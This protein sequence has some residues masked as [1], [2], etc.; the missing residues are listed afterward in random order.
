MR[1]LVPG[2][3]VGAVERCNTEVALARIDPATGVLHEPGHPLDG[4]SLAGKVLAC[5]GR[6]GS[7]SGS[8]ILMNLAHRGLAPAA[9]LVGRAD[10]VLVAGAVLGR[11]PLA[12]GINPCAFATGAKVDLDLP[13]SSR[14]AESPS[15]RILEAVGET[16]GATEMIPVASAH[17]GLSLSS[18]GETGVDFLESLVAR[19]ERFVVPATTNVLSF[20]RDELSSGEARLQRRALDALVRLGARANCSC[21]PFDQGL[22]PARGQSVAWSES[23][24]A[25]YVNGVLGARTNREGATALASALAGVTPRYGMHVAEHR[26]PGPRFRVTARLDSLDRFHLL[27]AAV[28]RRCGGAIPALEGLPAGSGLEALYG[29]SAALAAHS[30]VPMFHAVGVTPEAADLGT[31]YPEGAPRADV[32]DD[33]ALEAER[34]HWP[35]APGAPD[36]VVI[37]CPHATARQLKELAGLLRGLRVAKTRFIVHASREAREAARSTGDLGDIEAAGVQVTADTCSYVSA[38]AYAPGATLLTD[39]AKMA[40]LMAT[41]GL[42]PAIAS[43][44]DCVRAATGG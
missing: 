44:A 8:Y 27:G 29:F 16:F 15:M 33:E 38:T 21:N 7:S 28:A 26:R 5:K 25:P 9:L 30:P 6:K 2:R 22:G 1:V 23:A 32:L 4:R 39:S 11:V 20:P 18:L 43:V 37:G 10:A 41:R 24:T 17:I 34:R 12:Q 19:G 35:R 36:H 13:G 31:L 3:A 14:Q 40:F 42:R